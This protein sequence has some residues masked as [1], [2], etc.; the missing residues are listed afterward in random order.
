MS[1]QSSGIIGFI[2][3]RE[4][5]LDNSRAHTESP[6]TSHRVDKILQDCRIR[7]G[8]DELT[9]IV[10]EGIQRVYGFHPQRLAAHREDIRLMLGELDDTFQ[11]EKGGWSFLNACMDRR[12]DQWTDLHPTM[13]ALLV[14]G[15]ALDLGAFMPGRELW[16]ILPGG[17]PYYVCAKECRP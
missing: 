3:A 14:M 2:K 17:M 15:Q 5:A 1:D 4:Q 12:G 6:L 10:V 9:M 8:E 7:E 13:E 11:E 16:P